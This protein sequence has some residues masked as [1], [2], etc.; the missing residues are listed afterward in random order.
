M[1]LEKA[2]SRFEANELGNLQIAESRRVSKVK[3]LN[4]NQD[5]L[6]E[7]L[8]AFSTSIAEERIAS[9]KDRIKKEVAEASALAIEEDLEKIEN[10]GI[11]P[12]PKEEQQEFENDK[13]TLQLN[14]GATK[15]AAKAAMDNGSTFQDAQ[16]ITNLSGWALYA[17]TSRKSE[18]AGR[19]YKAWMEG[20]MLE[21]DELVVNLDG[22]EFKPN[23][24]KT[25][26]EKQAA[27]KALRQQFLIDNELT[28]I[29]RRL[30]AQKGG[31][32]EQASLAHSEIMTSF[33]KQDA[34][35]KS[36][37]I[38]KDAIETFKSDQNYTSLYTSLLTTVDKDGNRLTHSQALD[39]ADKIIKE[40]M[41]LDKFNSKELI[42]LGNQIV[43]HP[44]TGKPV[45]FKEAWPNRYA[46]LEVD[47]IE[48]DK[49]NNDN[50]IQER[51]NRFQE[52]EAAVLEEIQ[53]QLDADP[54]LVDSAFIERLTN[55]LYGKHIGFKSQ[56]LE[57][58]KKYSAPNQQAFKLQESEI[59]DLIAKNK[60][61]DEKLK[62]FDPRLQVKYKKEAAL[63]T[64]Q[65]SKSNALHLKH[66]D[67]L[68]THEVKARYQSGFAAGEEATQAWLKGEYANHLN[69]AILNEIED[70][71]KYA[72][73]KTQETWA[74]FV[75]NENNFDPAKGII[76][77]GFSH[78]AE[79]L[80]KI[81]TKIKVDSK[82]RLD[83]NTFLKN[84][85]DI[86]SIFTPEKIGGLIS[87]DKAITT[88][89][90]YQQNPKDFDWPVEVDVLFETLPEGS[91]KTK[92]DIMNDI[93]KAHGLP[94]LGD[95]EAIKKIASVCTKED[96]VSW[97]NNW[98]TGCR[99]LAK[100]AYTSGETNISF[101][102]EGEIF[103]EYSQITGFSV[104]ELSAGMELFEA[105]PQLGEAYGIKSE[106]GEV[107]WNRAGLALAHIWNQT[108]K[109][110]QM[111]ADAYKQ[112]WDVVT[113]RLGQFAGDAREEWGQMI[114]EHI[115]TGHD[116]NLELGKQLSGAA[117]GEWLA[118][119]LKEGGVA[120]S[121]WL[122][123][124]F[125]DVVES[126]LDVGELPKL[127]EYQLHSLNMKA[128]SLSG[129]SNDLQQLE[130]PR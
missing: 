47:L 64:T 89:K 92:A 3:N 63:I 69:I 111:G 62:T 49:E 114:D 60:L 15:I 90:S 100:I 87:R 126:I 10:E 65:T 70:P 73:A 102:P 117:A 13:T 91:G 2:L 88:L 55:Q 35:E 108:G 106:T 124:R 5:K 61:T 25:I 39:E 59:K 98:F 28:G 103:E 27:M 119:V 75:A 34:I 31:F 38:K 17:Y 95:S 43:T 105:Y 125:N 101:I 24:A 128:Y 115:E 122:S 121:K 77:P 37:L 107:D 110:F 79:E 45:P 36:F 41:K 44:Q 9:A 85:K 53:K 93:A 130:R 123:D 118:E 54:A 12:I 82:T 57:D 68:V 50:Y 7:Q 129:D 4:A 46:Q 67:S 94:D 80:K 42:D 40:E 11:N 32:Y 81:D 109:G 72:L 33:R 21:N 6:L 18:I 71:D 127:D 8:S 22:K 1:S 16:K 96:Q 84:N 112:V 48:A 78:S 51:K 97:T 30:L 14:D 104:S 19:N 29:N 26:E 58:F 116:K 120:S 86:V 56:M 74:A 20:Q 83:T 52:D 99:N 23:Q 76:V 66:L 113:G